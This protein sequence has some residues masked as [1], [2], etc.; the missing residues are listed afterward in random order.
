MSIKDR[1][2]DHVDLTA[3]GDMQYQTP[4]GFEQYRFIHNA[5]PEVNFDQVST[6]AELLG[7]T[8]SFPLFISSMTGG[9]TDAGAVNSIIAEFCEKHNLPFG[10]GSQRIMLE[11]PDT[12]ESFSIVREKAPTAFVASNIGGAQLIGGI[13]K[14]NLN[15]L[16]DSIKA[17]AIIV[18]LNP[19]QE[20]MQPEGDR[21]FK[22]IQNGIEQL[23]KDSP[24]PVIVKETGA[25]I[26]K[27]VAYRLLNLGVSVIDTAGA[28]GT[29]WAKVENER[30]INQDPKEHF[31]DWGISTVRSLQGILQLRKDFEYG[32]IASGGIRSS[33]DIAKSLCMGANFSASAQPVIQAIVKGGQEELE[34]MFQSWKKDLKIIL[35]LLGCKNLVELNSSHLHLA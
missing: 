28:G 27:E 8:F 6:K 18:H 19:L 2:K 3:G 21:N 25:G 14:Q 15:L 13:S 1:K 22:G 32:V 31:N 12:I 35:T 33:H 4:T 11:N 16:I 10:V 17:D 34:K 30:A 9:Y 26:S 20:L 5:L 29:S 23:V 24:I 7:R